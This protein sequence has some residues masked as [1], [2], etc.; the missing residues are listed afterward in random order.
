MES[1]GRF[2]CG[3]LVLFKMDRDG[4]FNSGGTCVA[5]NGQGWKV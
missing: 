3:G 1:D 4:R 2:E 5:E